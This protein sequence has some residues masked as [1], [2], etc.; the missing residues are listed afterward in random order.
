MDKTNKNDE[1]RKEC[2]DMADMWTYHKYMRSL[3]D[4]LF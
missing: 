1:E 4:N 3:L 2:V